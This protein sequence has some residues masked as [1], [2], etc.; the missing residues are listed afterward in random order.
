MSAKG[1]V[2]GSGDHQGHTYRR[3]A[4]VAL[5]CWSRSST[6]FALLWRW[7]RLSCCR[8]MSQ[9]PRAGPVGVCAQPGRFTC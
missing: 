3:S 6:S 5:D 1:P 4:F 2:R 9:P 8:G 7:R